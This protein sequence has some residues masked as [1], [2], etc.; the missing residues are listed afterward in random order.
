MG[1]LGYGFLGSLVD[2]S[3]LL[4]SLPDSKKFSTI[5]NPTKNFPLPQSKKIFHQKIRLQNF[6]PAP[7]SHPMIAR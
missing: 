7:T 3:K 6:F 5:Q 4:D 1:P 2:V